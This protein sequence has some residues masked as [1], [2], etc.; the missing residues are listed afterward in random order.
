M[1]LP[2]EWD[3]PE[4]PEDVVG[5]ISP[6]PLAIVHG[7]NDHLFSEDHAHRLFAA[8]GEPK[9]LLLGDHFGHAEDRAHAPVRAEA[10]P[11]RARGPGAAVVKVRL[12][13]MLREQAGAGELTD[14]EGRNVGELADALATRF[15][16]RFARWPRCRRSW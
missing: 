9:R 11:R 10:G 5:K 12:F 7:R 15:G 4:S 16:E 8:A 13:A 1:R 2:E 3:E 14:V 6:V